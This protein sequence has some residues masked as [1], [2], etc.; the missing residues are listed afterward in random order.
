LVFY[1]FHC[2]WLSP[3]WLELFLSI[4]FCWGYCEWNS[5][6]DFFFRKLILVKAIN[7]CMLTM[8]PD[9]LLEV[10]IRSESFLV[11]S[12]WPFQFTVI[13]SSNKNNLTSCFTTYISFISFSCF[14]ALDKNSRSILNKSR[15]NRHS[16]LIP[17]FRGN[18]FSFSKFRTMLT[19]VCHV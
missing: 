11:E 12:L 10:F 17:D 15:E 18:T 16:C 4:S 8:Y 13:S 2:R 19:S 1:N 6:H 5:F 3:L 7:F 9:T 14:I